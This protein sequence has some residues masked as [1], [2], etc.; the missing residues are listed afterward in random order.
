[1]AV[2]WAAFDID[3]VLA[4][5]SH[6][7]HHIAHRPKDWDAFF[8]RVSDDLLLSPG[9]DAVHQAVAMQWT[10]IYISGRPERCRHDTVEWL[11]FHG[12]PTGDVLLRSDDDRRPA[13]LVK[14]E[15]VRWLRT[16]G[17]VVLFVDDDEAVVRLLERDGVPTRLADWKPPEPSARTSSSEATSSESSPP[18]DDVLF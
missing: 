2:Q 4:D 14:R 13:A 9:L 15:Y 8:S 10:P 6:R 16:R 7:L 17:D 1:M 5:N 11:R 18:P 12:F 3:G